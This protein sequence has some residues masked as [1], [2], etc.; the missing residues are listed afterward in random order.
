MNRWSGGAGITGP[1]GPPDTVAD[2][3]RELN[4]VISWVP[5][6]LGTDADV[7]E[8]PLTGYRIGVKDNIEIAGVRST[9]GSEFFADRVAD[10]DAA[11]V[12]RLKRAG[13]TI[14]CTLN[15]AEFAVGVTSQN[16]AAG[17]PRN[18]WDRTRVPGGSSGGSGAAVAAGLV[19]IA[20]GTDTGGS[21]RL[22]AACCGVTGLRPSLG[23]IGTSGIHPVSP[24]FDTVGPLARTVAEVRAACAVLADGDLP[25]PPRDRLRIAVPRPFITTDIDPSIRDA[26]DRTVRL[27]H[28]LGH[29]LLDTPVPHSESAQD[30]VYTLLYSDLVEVHAERLR[31]EPHRFQDATRERISLGLNITHEQRVAALQQ[32]DRFRAAMRD[33]FRNA[34]VILTPT[35]PID[36]PFVDGG[37]GVVAQSRRM[38]Q[39][40]YPWSLHDGPTMSIPIGFH[41]RSAM[42][43]GAQL[44]AARGGETTLFALAEQLESRTTWHRR[45]PP[46]ALG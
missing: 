4:T 16:S 11:V 9:C 40:T 10:S 13:A 6:R 28:R 12:T 31:D 7:T 18:P 44:T 25:P 36:V 39:L 20:L 1:S 45:L 23:L 33:Y 35:M 30:V 14:T 5:E 8:G 22:P 34:D 32:R 2:I 17:G 29:T 3:A 27:L 19:D 42:P 43:I 46:L 38:A 15:L 26:L 24:D 41:E 37:T 21:I